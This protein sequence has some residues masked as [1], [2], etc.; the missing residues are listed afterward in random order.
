MG[1]KVSRTCSNQAYKLKSGKLESV[2]EKHLVARTP[3]SPDV[4]RCDVLR[5]SDPLEQRLHHFA[6][7]FK[8]NLKRIILKT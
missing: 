1:C 8:H 4:L 5:P 7:H 3:L 6:H 2:L